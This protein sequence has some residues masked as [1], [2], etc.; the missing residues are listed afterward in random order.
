MKSA[1]RGFTLIELMVT[2]AVV[3]ILAA[4]AYPAYTSYLAKGNRSEAL[5]EL[6][7]LAGIE[8]QYRLDHRTYTA[9]LTKVG[10]S[11]SSYTVAKGTFTISA[12]AARD[13]LTL[14]ATASSGQQQKD[15]SCAVLSIDETG[16]KA[17]KD[18]SGGVSDACW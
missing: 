10:G 1:N 5:T 12:S 17:A 13:T 3:A 14:T 2:V 15:G 8:E 18:S 9:D 6:M 11:A 4:I 16:H 7:R